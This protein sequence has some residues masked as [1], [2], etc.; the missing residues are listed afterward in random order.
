MNTFVTWAV[1]A[2]LI[3]IATIVIGG[4]LRLWAFRRRGNEGRR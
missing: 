3:A 4:Q 2:V 1:L